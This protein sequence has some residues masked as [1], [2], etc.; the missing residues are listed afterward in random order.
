MKICNKCMT[1]YTDDIAFCPKCGKLLSEVIDNYQCPSCKRDLGKEPPIFCPYCG[2]A[3][4]IALP[5]NNKWLGFKGRIQQQEYLLKIIILSLIPVLLGYMFFTSPRLINNFIFDFLSFKLNAA[6]FIILGLLGIVLFLIITSLHVRR[7]RD[8]NHPVWFL[9]A[10]YV[11]NAILLFFLDIKPII[12]TVICGIISLYLA[13]G[14]SAYDDNE[15]QS[16]FSGKVSITKA[17]IIFIIAFLIV[18]Y[19]G[20]HNHL[21]MERMVA[22]INNIQKNPTE[23]VLLEDL[24]FIKIPLTDL[25]KSDISKAKRLIKKADYYNQDIV[26]IREGTS[27]AKRFYIALRVEKDDI[28][29]L[30]NNVYT[31]LADDKV[32]ANDDEDSFIKRNMTPYLKKE[33]FTIKKFWK[34]EMLAN[35]TWSAVLDCSINNRLEYNSQQAFRFFNKGYSY[36][37]LF[38]YNNDKFKKSVNDSI[39]TIIWKTS[40]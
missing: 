20:N 40:Y 7:L 5:V 28:M 26:S 19:C 36:S 25:E 27:G 13:L 31:P 17:K 4:N 8:L 1:E 2:K 34:P 18:N 39:N 32:Y 10:W 23:W 15:A 11:I 14:N 33:D 24:C 22:T 37:L 6:P 3:T 12:F 21:E 38:M 9:L 16:L 30:T 29:P 35:N